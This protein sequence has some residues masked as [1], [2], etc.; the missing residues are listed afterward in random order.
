MANKR[1]STADPPEA[2]GPSTG[3]NPAGQ[4]AAHQQG[5]Q[6]TKSQVPNPARGDLPVEEGKGEPRSTAGDGQTR[7]YDGQTRVYEGES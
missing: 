4:R 2:E 5:A 3:A 6:G 7:V 1:R